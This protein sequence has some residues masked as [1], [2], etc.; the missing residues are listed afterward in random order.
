MAHMQM[1]GWNTVTIGREEQ[2]QVTGQDLF[3]MIR[4]LDPVDYDEAVRHFLEDVKRGEESP[5]VLR[6][7]A[8]LL[9]QDEV[10]LAPELKEMG[11]EPD[12]R[13]I[14]VL[15]ALGADP[16]V[17]NA[18]GEPPLHLAA[19]YGYHA[20]VRMLIQAGADVTR[21]NSRGQTARELAS[22]EIMRELLTPP[23]AS[24]TEGRNEVR[25]E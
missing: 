8:T 15:L 20:I 18:Y 5:E 14:E 9:L 13:L 11:V 1:K 12:E 10:D 16:D 21:R 19:R 7:A 3:E 4:Q 23:V 22:D 2:P 25:G 24:E 17:P 6:H